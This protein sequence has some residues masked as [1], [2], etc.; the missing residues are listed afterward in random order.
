MLLNNRVFHSNS[1]RYFKHNNNCL[2]LV[3]FFLTVRTTVDILLYYVYQNLGELFASGRIF[4][5]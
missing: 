3:L 4:S 1:I 5:V 2:L